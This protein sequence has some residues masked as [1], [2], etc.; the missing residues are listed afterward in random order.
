[1]IVMSQIYDI[2][3]ADIQELLKER[4]VI[5]CKI[6]NTGLNLNVSIEV[7]LDG[8]LAYEETSSKDMREAVIHEPN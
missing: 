5:T 4:L 8:Q 2:T 3:I 7:L 6:Y 1:M